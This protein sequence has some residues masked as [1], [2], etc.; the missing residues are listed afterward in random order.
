M[1]SSVQLHCFHRPEGEGVP[2]SLNSKVGCLMPALSEVEECRKAFE[3]EGTTLVV[4][5]KA[6]E[7]VGALAPGESAVYQIGDCRQ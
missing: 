1:L 2:P 7:H 4:P 6:S 5:L 3:W